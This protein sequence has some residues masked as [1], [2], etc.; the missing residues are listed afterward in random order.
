MLLNNVYKDH[1]I[2][3]GHW[4][5]KHISLGEM[6]GTINVRL[7]TCWWNPGVA[8]ASGAGG[9]VTADRNIVGEP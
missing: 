8:T 6:F 9:Q 4:Y 1:S 7:Y 5:R 2:N 3:T